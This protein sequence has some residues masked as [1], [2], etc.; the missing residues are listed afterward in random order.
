MELIEHGNLME[1][2]ENINKN[3]QSFTEKDACGIIKQ[4][5]MAL[6]Y[7]HKKGVVHRDLKA[8]NVMVDV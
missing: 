7:M 6:N 5:L 3:G 1:V 4:I 8:E 2:F